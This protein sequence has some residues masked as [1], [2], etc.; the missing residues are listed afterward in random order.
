M[1]VIKII[2]KSFDVFQSLFCLR[3]CSLLFRIVCGPKECVIYK[4]CIIT[5]CVDGCTDLRRH[6]R[7]AIAVDE[8]GQA[9]RLD[10][11]SR[12]VSSLTS[13]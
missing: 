11:W 13:L 8:S 1:E 2:K 7:D 3:L 10:S 4:T 5:C 6:V 9:S 12:H